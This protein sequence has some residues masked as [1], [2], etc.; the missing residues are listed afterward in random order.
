MEQSQDRPPQ[1]PTLDL[2]GWE[3]ARATDRPAVRDWPPRRQVLITQRGPQAA[4]G[5]VRLDLFDATEAGGAETVMTF[6]RGQLHLADAA[7]VQPNS[8]A[9]GTLRWHYRSHW[10]VGRGDA[11][12][13]IRSVDRAED[14]LES[15]ADQ[16]A[17]ALGAQ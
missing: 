1:F 3:A 14:H 10:M 13:V 6:L 15:I 8:A 5:L 2:P 11:V 17:Q 9:D 16:V 12:V 7:A 4:G